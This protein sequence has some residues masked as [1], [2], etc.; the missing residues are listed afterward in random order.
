MRSQNGTPRGPHTERP[1]LPLLQLNPYIKNLEP[2]KIPPVKFQEIVR[3]GQAT[4]VARM[5][6]AT[7]SGHAFILRRLDTGAISSTTMFRAAF[8]T[9]SDDAERAESAWIKSNYNIAG[10]NKQGSARFAGTWVT[11]EVALE[12][13]QDYQLADV[14]SLLTDATPDPQ[15]VFRKSGKTLQQPTPGASPVTPSQN[16]TDTPPVKRR[17]EAS[18][19]V[20]PARSQPTPRRAPTPQRN[21]ALA[22]PRRSTRLMSPVP[23][24]VTTIVSSTTKV[25]STIHEPTT[26]AGSDETAVEEE[27]RELAK[28]A[29]QNMEED[30]R[31]Q[32]ELVNRLKAEAEAKARAAIAGASLAE[33]ENAVVE[34]G[35]AAKR[36]REEEPTQY[37]LD[38]KE[39]EIGERAIATNRRV[40]GKMTPERKSLAWGALLFAA[41]VGAVSFLPSI[42]GF[43]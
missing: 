9:V 7:P 33:V 29:E 2:S 6:I 31:E 25:V 15:V 18:P 41:G 19:A 4:I 11:P 39:P 16:V 17:R 35:P 22:S 10:A 3:D 32:K 14:I 27:A 38:I 1:L 20:T 5:K 37:T 23:L 34:G 36:A 13:A 12:L 42:P 28:V 30:I 40:L 26:P 21:A 8:P 43:F 24:P